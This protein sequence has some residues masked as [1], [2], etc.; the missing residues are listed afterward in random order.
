MAQSDA[1]Q[2]LML[3]YDNGKY[4]YYSNK[5]GEIVI[6][7][8]FKLAKNFTEGLAA[9]NVNGLENEWGYIDTSGKIVIAPQFR[10]ATS[11]SEGLAGVEIYSETGFI[12]Q[13]SGNKFRSLWGYIDKS[14]NFVISP[15]FV[16]AFPFING[17]ARFWTGA[18]VG[19]NKYGV[20]DKTGK[21]IVEAKF[22]NIASDFYEGLAPFR[23]GNKWGF[24]DTSGKIVI[25]PNFDSASRFSEGFA[26]VAWKNKYDVFIWGFINR[27]G[28]I[29][30]QP[31]FSVVGRFSE[32]LAKFSKFDSKYGYINKTGR[33]IIKAQF[34]GAED[35]S[36][37]SA[38]VFTRTKK[39]CIDLHGSEQFRVKVG[40]IDRTGK[41]IEKPVY[42]DVCG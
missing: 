22:D 21:E 20:I 10:E 35:F 24:I 6:K 9:V 3:T 2:D 25:E 1:S 16:Y 17:V 7:P 30:I 39:K 37:G 41:F 13:R 34:D 18:I 40:L 29:V 42:Q 26:A 8:Q 4:G 23:I 32:G 33:V 14:G 5:N 38:E 12:Y 11:F 15:Q 31:Q 28:K 36:R 19:Q 27:S